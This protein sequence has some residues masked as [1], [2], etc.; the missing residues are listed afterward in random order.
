MFDDST[1]KKCSKC[2]EVKLRGEFNRYK[3]NKNGLTPDCKRCRSEYRRKWNFKNKE[4]V[5]ESSRKWRLKNKERMS[6]Y[7]REYK[8]ENKEKVSEYNREY[9]EENKEKVSEYN[10]E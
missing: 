9:K 1:H 10:R 7:N 2:G 8:E 4:K 6:K 5:N 3:R